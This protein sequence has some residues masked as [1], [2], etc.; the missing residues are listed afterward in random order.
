VSDPT[1]GVMTYKKI[2]VLEP[3]ATPAAFQNKKP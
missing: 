3:A 2:E 1:Y